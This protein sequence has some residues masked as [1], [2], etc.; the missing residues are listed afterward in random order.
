MAVQGINIRVLCNP[1]IFLSIYSK[2]GALGM[3]KVSSYEKIS[4]F[5]S[6]QAAYKISFF[7]VL[8]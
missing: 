4:N 2:L 6:A 7:S 3:N 8:E 1:N 5:P